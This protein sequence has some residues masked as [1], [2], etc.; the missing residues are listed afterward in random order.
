MM[1]SILLRMVCLD[2]NLMDF[3]AWK[4]DIKT[5]KRELE[6]KG[7]SPIGINAVINLSV[8]NIRK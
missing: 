6:I 1:D 2:N 5:E 7:K 3:F 4:Y 8:E